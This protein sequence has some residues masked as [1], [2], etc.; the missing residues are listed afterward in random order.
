M[1]EIP[2]LSDER[3]PLAMRTRA[4]NAALDLVNA[5]VAFQTQVVMKGW[6]ARPTDVEEDERAIA[7][8][9][10]RAA[11]AEFRSAWVAIANHLDELEQTEERAKFYAAHAVGGLTA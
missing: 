11:L 1:P 5:E 2:A 9:A 3:V 8:A 4:A 7:T 10:Y 6:P